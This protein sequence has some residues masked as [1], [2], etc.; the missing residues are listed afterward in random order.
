MFEQPIANKMAEMLTG[1]EGQISLKVFGPDLAVLNEKIREIHDVL[2]DRPGIADLQVEQTTGIPL[3]L[4]RLDREAL[5]RHGIKVDE[6]ADVIETAL[7][8]VEVTD[9]IE[10]DRMTSVLVRLPEKYR[11]ESAAIRNLLVDTPSGHRIPLS[12]LAADRARRR[13]AD[14]FPRE[15]AKAQDHPL[16]RGRTR[17]RRVRGGSQGEDRPPGEAAQ[18][19]LT[20]PSAASSKASNRPCSN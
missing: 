8:G 3:V 20:S 4:I 11:R 7:N 9:V 15:H 5:A 6:V 14:H 17:H 10:E 2:H 12:Q 16:Q 13:S 18:G 19:I 1:T